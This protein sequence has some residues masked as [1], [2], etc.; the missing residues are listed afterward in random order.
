[1]W[2]SHKIKS[3]I[4][5]LTQESCT[6]IYCCLRLQPLSSR[7]LK[8]LLLDYLFL[9]NDLHETFKS[10][11]ESRCFTSTQKQP[12]CEQKGRSHHV[13]VGAVQ[14][15]GGVLRESICK[16]CEISESRSQTWKDFTLESRREA[17]KWWAPGESER[18]RASVMKDHGRGEREDVTP[19]RHGT[20]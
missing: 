4:I 8:H 18:K 3:A 12:K 15:E 9:S 1:M 5:P 2:P 7:V 20:T 11:H 10:H 13:P 17:L 19:S 6:R 14:S 16:I